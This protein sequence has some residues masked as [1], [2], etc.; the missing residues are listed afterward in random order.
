S[1]EEYLQPST[2]VSFLQFKMLQS[3]QTM[4]WHTKSNHIVCLSLLAIIAWQPYFIAAESKS[5]YTEAL[6]GFVDNVLL[7]SNKVP[8]SSYN[9]ND[10]SMD[11]LIRRLSAA[12]LSRGGI[13]RDNLDTTWTLDELLESAGIGEN[14]T[15]DL[16]LLGE[17]VLRMKGWA[18][19]FIDSIGRPQAGLL[20]GATTWLGSF[21]QCLAAGANFTDENGTVESEQF[22]GAYCL[23]QLQSWS[24]KSKLKILITIGTCWPDSCSMRDAVNATKHLA[25]FTSVVDVGRLDVRPAA[26][27]CRSAAGAKTDSLEPGAIAML[28]ILS[29]IAACLIGGTGIDLYQRSRSRSAAAAAAKAPVQASGSASSA[30]AAVAAEAA[31]VGY[32]ADNNGA[33]NDFD[34]S[35]TAGD[36]EALIAATV[37]HRDNRGG[38]AGIGCCRCWG[39][40]KS[41]LLCFSVRTNAAK[42]MDQRQASSSLRCVNGIRFISMSWVILS[43]TYMVGLINASNLG[44]L[45]PQW[46]N[47]WTFQA[48]LNAT[49]SVDTFFVLSGLLATYLFL[50][51]LDRRGGQLKRINWLR[52]YLHRYWRLTAPYMLVLG[53]YTTLAQYLYDGP[54]YPRNGFDANCRTVWWRNLLYINNFFSMRDMCMSWSWYLAN[55]MQFYAVSPLFMTLMAKRPALGVAAA[56]L[57]IVASSV[58]LGVYCTLAGIGVFGPGTGGEEMWNRDA[59][60]S[61]YIRPWFRIGPYLVGSLA[62]MLTHRLLSAEL[63]D[64]RFPYRRQR[65]SLRLHWSVR[66]LGWATAAVLCLS[67]LYGLFDVQRGLVVLSQPVASLYNATFR[68]AWSIGIAWVVVACCTGNG[69]LVSE[70]L[71]A[72]IFAPL[73]RLSY[74]AYL[75]HPVIIVAMETARR[76]TFQWNSWTPVGNFLAYLATS[77]GVAF[78][79]SLAFESPLIALERLAV[80]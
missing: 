63:V 27:D 48:V 56:M 14:C 77:Y 22:S 54:R 71:S 38:G 10:F 50:R 75:L 46:L 34:S 47:D 36:E 21:D 13:F 58:G 55:D 20:N 43:H 19:P 51:E 8:L 42:L 1:A 17:A 16:K 69:G 29:L 64:A 74:C 72:G 49:V 2:K 70:F 78:G 39:G 15:R 9:S 23:L 24:D 32:N 35:E 18:L 45:V 12:S 44:Q 41:I 26:P 3:L 53:A 60:D 67:V 52:F 40:L 59:L 76:D 68:L 5:A 4:S 66:L 57:A 80:E 33:N 28:A 7:S 25:N 11:Q 37:I 30:A 31:A 65:G 6:L 61:I 62:G 79:A 73:S